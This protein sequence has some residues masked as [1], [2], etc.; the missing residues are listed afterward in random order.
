MWYNA[1]Q[2]AKILADSN[3]GKSGGGG[4]GLAVYLSLK[5]SEDLEDGSDDED[6]PSYEK[7]DE[8]LEKVI[9]FVFVKSA[10][11]SSINFHIQD[12]IKIVCMQH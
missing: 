12:F 2:R 5:G 8:M 1:F 3:D 10:L 4:Q 6:E 7:P 11:P 9:I